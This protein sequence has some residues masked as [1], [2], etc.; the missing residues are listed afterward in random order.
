MH[1]FPESGRRHYGTDNAPER[2]NDGGDP[3][4]DTAKSREPKDALETAWHQPEDSWPSGGSAAQRQIIELV[5]QFPGPPSCPSSRRPSSLRFTS[6]LCCL[7]PYKAICKLWTH[8]PDRFT[9]D[10]FHQMPGLTPN[11]E[12]GFVVGGCTPTDQ[13]SRKSIE[14]P[15][16]IHSASLQRLPGSPLIK[17]SWRRQNRL[18]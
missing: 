6:T 3:S 2:H 18:R 1:T 13:S 17:S 4:S 15:F 11:V 14:R 5:Q 7:T 12:T 10:P 9:L 8:D 16:S